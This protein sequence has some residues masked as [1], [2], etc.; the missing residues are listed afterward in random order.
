MEKRGIRTN[1][2]DY[3][4]EAA[5]SNKE[6]AQLKARIRKAKNW[7]CAQ[8][9]C[10]A[11]T[12][13][14]MMKGLNNGQN[15]ISNWQKISNLKQSAQ[16]LMFLQNNDIKSMEQLAD[17][18]IETHKRIYELSNT[19]KAKERRISKLNDHLENVDIY[20]RFITIHKKYQSLDI[21]K[22]D[23]YKQKYTDELAQFDLAHAYIKTHLHGRTNIPKEAWSDERKTLLSERLPLVEEYYSLK[24]DVKSI[25]TLR[26]RA[27]GMMTEILPEYKSFY[28]F[29]R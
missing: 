20:N 2:G 29:G 27:E 26:R 15:L 14:E 22:R 16:V 5:V 18:I 17:K 24:E 11:P 1:R 28:E 25:E 6:I 19:I 3:N 21:K 13:A 8:P 9:I 23:A 10:S 7:I 4:R 12:M